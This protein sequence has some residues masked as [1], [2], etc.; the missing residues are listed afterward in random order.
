MRATAT[1]IVAPTYTAQAEARAI[2]LAM[3][4]STAQAQGTATALAQ[5]RMT[6]AAI[7]TATSQAAIRATHTAAAE[8]T[9]TTIAQATQTAAVKQT[10]TAAA[11]AT[12]TAVAVRTA[13]AQAAATS[14]TEATRTAAA[15]ATGTAAAIRTATAAARPTSTYTPSPYKYPAPQLQSPPKG[16][17]FTGYVS[18]EFRWQ[19][20]APQ[21]AADEYY[22]LVIT[23]LHRDGHRYPYLQATTKDTRWQGQLNPFLYDSDVLA[24][25]GSGWQHGW[26][27]VVMRNPGTDSR[28][29]IMG[30]QLSP[31][32]E[33]R[34]FIWKLEVGAPGAPGVPPTPTR[35]PK[36]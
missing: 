1:A 32:S 23:F 19:A 4:S 28:G 26:Y 8:A 7:A 36:V 3:A 22:V 30:T 29:Q 31:R 2:A 13:T 33:E 18:M 11:H 27:V 34:P 20:V 24:D 15:R 14:A 12:S 21:L 10:S 16:A 6:A 25:R 35:T 5:S 9:Q 17:T